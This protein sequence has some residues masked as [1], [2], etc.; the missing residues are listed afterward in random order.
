MRYRDPE[1]AKL[2]EPYVCIVASVYR[3]TPRDYDELG[4]RVEC[5][6]FGTVTCGEHIAAETELYAKYFD[7]QR[8]SPRHLVLEPDGAKTYD[9]YYSWDTATVLSTWREGAKNP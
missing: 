3:H 4:R 7:G 6:R 2:L 5:P 1:T 8:I 9:V